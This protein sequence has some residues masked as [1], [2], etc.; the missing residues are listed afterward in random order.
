[1]VVFLQHNLYGIETRAQL[2]VK[3]EC[4]VGGKW[5]RRGRGFFDILTATGSRTEGKGGEKKLKRPVR[6][7]PENATVTSSYATRFKQVRKHVKAAQLLSVLHE[8][9]IR[10]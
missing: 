10:Y 7:E 6:T 4:R 3:G 1:M 2:V 9:T 8:S 5:R